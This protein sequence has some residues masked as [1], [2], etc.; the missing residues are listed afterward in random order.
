MPNKIFEIL[1]LVFFFVLNFANAQIILYPTSDAFTS[2]SQTSNNYGTGQDIRIKKSNDGNSDRYG[3]LTFNAN[4]VTGTYNQVLLKLTQLNTQVGGVLLKSFQGTINETTLTWNN[5]PTV[6]E[7]IQYGGLRVN[8]DIYFDVTAYVNQQRSLN[9]DINFIIYSQTITDTFQTFGSRE[10]T[11]NTLKPQLQFFVNSQKDIPVFKLIDVVT[12]I[13]DDNGYYSNMDQ[14]STL[15]DYK[16]TF[17]DAV[18]AYGGLISCEHSYTPTGYFRTEKIDNVWHLIDPLGN[19]FYTVGL[20]SV[21][22]GGGINLPNELI[23]MGVNTMG[24]WSDE[25]IKNIPYCPRLN[26]LVEFKNVRQD[27]KDTYR[28]DVLPVFE[29]DFESYML[30]KMPIWLANYINDP[31]VL[32]YFMDN[33]LKFSGT[34]LED[35]LGLGTLLDTNN[36]Q[37]KKADEYMK[38][39]Y[40]N[41]YTLSQITNADEEAYLTMVADKY[42]SVISNAIRIADPNHLILGS[43]LNGNVRYRV[44]VLS[45]ATKYIDV[46]S[47]NYYREWEPQDDAIALWASTTNIPWFTSEFYVKGNDYGLDNIDGAGWTVPSQNERAEFFENWVLKTMTDPNCVGYHWFRYIDN[48]GSNKGV[49]NESYQWYTQLKESFTQINKSKYA[50]RDYVLHGFST[51]SC[52]EPSLSTNDFTVNKN[53]LKLYPNPYLSGNLHFEFSE[54]IEYDIINIQIFDLNGKILKLYQCTSNSIDLSELSSNVYILKFYASNQFIG[55]KKLV[56]N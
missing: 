3:Y 2:S 32:G 52:N 19:L 37:Y 41:S 54:D 15:V 17:V 46:L 49:I 1:F 4:T 40:G 45:S 21:E 27:V 29:S 33:E 16:N 36:A 42:Y 47:I 25:T 56:K 38:S 5:H 48:N 35:S 55:V 28:A 22:E 51:K 44:S 7:Y 18:D 50:L 39:V 23:N 14:N 24:S 43:R 8:D 13:T 30:T 31:W 20:N 12:S 53:Q 6:T 11:N 9:Q 26:A 34:Q 10:N